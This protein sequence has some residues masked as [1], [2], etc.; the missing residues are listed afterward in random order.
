MCPNPNDVAQFLQIYFISDEGQ[1][2]ERRCEIFNMRE[3]ERAIVREIQQMLHEVNVYVRTFKMNLD[4]MNNDQF[5]IL[6]RADKRPAGA[7]ARQYNAPTTDEIAVIIPNYNANTGAQRRDILLRRRCDGPLQKI[8]ETHRSY[9]AL[10]YPLMF[11]RGEDGYHLQI[12]MI[13]PISGE[14]TISLR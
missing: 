10:Q 12:N 2:V 3:K 7:H 4:H 8:S 13:N 11:P 14:L 6:I 1:Q 9:D 5:N